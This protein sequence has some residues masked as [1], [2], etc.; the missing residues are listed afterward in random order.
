MR[1]ESG[2]AG[3]EALFCATAS[4]QRALGLADGVCSADKLQHMSNYVLAIS[5]LLP[6][7]SSV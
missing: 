5:Y 1:A 3:V 4:L 6:Y 2:A 7:E